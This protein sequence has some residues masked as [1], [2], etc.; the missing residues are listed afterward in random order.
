MTG[1]YRARWTVDNADRQRRDRK[2]GSNRGQTLE[3]L[4]RK[5][6][7]CFST[8]VHCGQ[9]RA[10]NEVTFLLI[11]KPHDFEPLSHL[12]FVSCTGVLPPGKSRSLLEGFFCP[13]DSRY[14]SYL[15][16]G[17]PGI[18]VLWLLPPPWPLGVTSGHTATSKQKAGTRLGVWGQIGGWRWRGSQL[19][20]GVE[21][22]LRNTVEAPDHV[23]MSGKCTQ[24]A[25]S[26]IPCLVVL[27]ES[28]LPTS[29]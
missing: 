25:G 17:K 2:G 5:A 3:V 1:G 19:L 26:C 12:S 14:Y 24:E 4:T 18:L 23:L 10:A 9:L 15:Q 8:W 27:R 29:C 13:R 28:F 16:E 11:F 20:E 7:L 21:L 22:R 6:F